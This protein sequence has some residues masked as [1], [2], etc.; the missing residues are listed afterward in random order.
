MANSVPPA[1]Y[2]TPVVGRDGMMAAAW[3]SWIRALFERVGGNI[4]P[5][6]LELSGST[7]SIQSS[8]AG[9][10]AAISAL[11]GRVDELESSAG[12]LNQ[13]RVL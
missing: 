10:Q 5:T 7:G 3:V 12:G 4:A 8:L 9:A 13:G 6:N 2:R 1:P 11:Q